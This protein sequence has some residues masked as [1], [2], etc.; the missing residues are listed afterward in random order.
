MLLLWL[1]EIL[2]PSWIYQNYNHIEDMY[3]IFVLFLEIHMHMG[4]PVYQKKGSH[5][6]LQ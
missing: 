5:Y 1:S 6:I 2:F 4:I 3:G